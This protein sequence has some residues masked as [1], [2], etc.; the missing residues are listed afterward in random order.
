MK[1]CSTCQ[2]IKPVEQFTKEKGRPDGLRSS[3][4]ECQ[5]ARVKKWAEKDPENARQ[6]RRAADARYRAKNP[7]LSAGKS[8]LK[9]GLTKEEYLTGLSGICACCQRRPAAVADH[10]H[11][12]GVVRGFLCG[13]CNIALGLLGDTLDDVRKAMLYLENTVQ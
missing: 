3:C 2:E 8:A 12:T 11:V 4:K 9:Y 6:K 1:K 7:T 5:S 13:P 10:D